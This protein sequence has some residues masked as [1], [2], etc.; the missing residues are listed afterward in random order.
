MKKECMDAATH[1]KLLKTQVFDTE[2]GKYLLTF[3]RYKGGIYMFKYLDGKLLECGDLTK[4][5]G[6]EE[7]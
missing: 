6:V 5:K 2:R 1:G 4:M 3:R 7:K